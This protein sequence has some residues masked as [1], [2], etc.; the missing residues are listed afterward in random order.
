MFNISHS[1]FAK[2]SISNLVSLSHDK[3]DCLSKPIHWFQFADDAAVVTTNERKNK[4]PLNCFTKWCTRS[5]MII[6]VDKCVTFGIQKFSPHFLQYEPK[7][8]FNNEYV[9]TFKSGDSFKYLSHYFNFQMENEVHKEKLK[10]S[11][12]D[13]LTRI[14]VLPVLPKNKLLLYQRYIFSKLSWHLTVATLPKTWAIQHSTS[15]QVLSCSYN[16][17]KAF[18]FYMMTRATRN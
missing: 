9:P 5:D 16:K 15:N 13:M 1:I 2:N 4:I 12:P 3:L 8:F 18:L 7:L 10:S 14:D 11:L 6:S 17:C